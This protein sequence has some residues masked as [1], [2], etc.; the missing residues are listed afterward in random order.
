MVFQSLPPCGEAMNLDKDNK[1][2]EALEQLLI[3]RIIYGAAP[4]P[5]MVNPGLITI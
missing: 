5:E 3:D 2:L 4:Q 1:R